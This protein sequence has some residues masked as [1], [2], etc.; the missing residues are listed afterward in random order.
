LR[1]RTKIYLSIL[2]VSVLS[3][4][5]GVYF[6]FNKSADAL[7]FELRTKVVSVAATA[8]ALID[9]K[10]VVALS[11]DLTISNPA[12]VRLQKELIEARDNNR[13]PDFFVKYIYIMKP[14]DN[15]SSR[16]IFLVEAQN[17]VLPGQYDDQESQSQIYYH[18]NEFYSPNKLIKDKWGV[19]MSGFSPIVDDEGNYIAT[20]GVDISAQSVKA[21]LNQII[22]FAIIATFFSA[23]AALLV[24]YYLAHRMTDALNYISENLDQVAEGNLD[25]CVKIDSNDEFGKLSATINHMI[26]GLKER[27]TLKSSFSK[28]VSQYVMDEI[29]SEK[30]QVNLQGERKKITVLF[31]DIRHFTQ[32]SENMS[33][34]NVVSLLNEYFEV[35][36]KVIF[37]HQ[38]TI[39]KFMGDGIMVEFGAPLTDNEQEIHAVRCGLEMLEALKKLNE[40]FLKEDRPTLSIG[41]GIHSGYAIM[42]N[43]GS[44]TRMEYTAIGDCVNVASRL[45][46]ATKVYNHPILVSEDVF[47]ALSNNLHGKLIGSISLPGRSKE[48]TVYAITF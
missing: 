13:R 17:A 1:F 44:E 29:L 48:I 14:E 34:E 31:S 4:L 27:D 9:P 32:I 8:A 22:N 33:P 43:I 37:K 19:W 18:L 47:N 12:F 11:Q 46:Q 42:G 45:E 2:A 39:D 35:M 23:L 3:L 38:G 40:K 20:L 15:V 21:T 5:G 6:L 25:I 7:K 10:D 26:H 36:L 30:K 41:I 28:Y 16:M 24:A